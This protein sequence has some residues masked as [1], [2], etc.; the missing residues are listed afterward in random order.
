MDSEIIKEA[1]DLQP[2]V[3][4]INTKVNSNPY[5][6]NFQILIDQLQTDWRCVDPAK[7]KNMTLSS[8]LL[9]NLPNMQPMPC[10]P[11]FF[12]I[13]QNY[14]KVSFIFSSI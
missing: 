13:S 10:K 1:E 2:K 12:D 9:E 4:E 3:D 6:R 11:M 7:L 5:K 8:A 14:L